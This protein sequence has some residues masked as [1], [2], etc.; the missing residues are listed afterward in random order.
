MRMRRIEAGALAWE[1]RPLS[2]LA[3]EKKNHTPRFTNYITKAAIARAMD[4]QAMPSTGKVKLV[5][6]FFYDLGDAVG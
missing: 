2:R 5:G 3:K 4:M 6:H 1:C